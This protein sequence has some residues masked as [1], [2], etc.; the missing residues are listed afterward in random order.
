MIHSDPIVSLSMLTKVP[1]VE[2]YI[3]TFGFKEFS[4]LWMCWT[5]IK[6]TKC[7]DATLGAGHGATFRRK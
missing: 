3:G 7:Q 5:L 6:F 4:N 2:A 1:F